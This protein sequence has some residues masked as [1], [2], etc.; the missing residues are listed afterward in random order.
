MGGGSLASAA[1]RFVVL[2]LNRVS[3]GFLYF[4]VL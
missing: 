3:V 4:A 1:I 2:T